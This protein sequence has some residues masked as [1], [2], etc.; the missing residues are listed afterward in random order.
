MGLSPMRFKDY[1]WPHNPKIYEITFERKLAVHKVP[2]GRYCIQ[3][4]GMGYRVLRGEGEFAGSGAYDE[5]KKL[6]SVFYDE[7]AGILIHP[8]WQS[9][10]AYFV[11]L[12]LKQ[13]PREDYVSYAFEFWEDYNGYKTVLTSPSNSNSTDS[14][15]AI[16]NGQSASY[17]VVAGDTLWGIA[18]RN[19]MTVDGLLVLNP[20]I[21]N[22]NL[23]YPG[24]IIYL[25]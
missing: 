1:V 9:A 10:K 25:S 22:P 13:E 3:N 24:D 12:R 19:G 23:I 4:M 14:S 21:S 15:G 5:F 18:S 8:I 17:T 6:A 20:Q 2:F 7:T 11:S 16:P